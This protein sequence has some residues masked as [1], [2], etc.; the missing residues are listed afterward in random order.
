MFNRGF[1]KK[2]KNHEKIEKVSMLVIWESGSMAKQIDQY[3]TYAYCENKLNL[4]NG[5]SRLKIIKGT[6]SRNFY[7]FCF[8]K[9][10][11]KCTGK[12]GFANCYVFAKIFDL[13]VLNSCVS[14]S[15]PI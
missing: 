12:N 5:K 9:L 15:W 10:D 8:V 7:D 13:N 3:F 6:V 4:G 11:P 14:V 1:Q 2:T